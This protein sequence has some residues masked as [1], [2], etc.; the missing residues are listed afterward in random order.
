MSSQEPHRRCPSQGQVPQELLHNKGWGVLGAMDTSS[1]A[2]PAGEPTPGLARLLPAS[3][4]VL[5]EP[6]QGPEPGPELLLGLYLVLPRS[7]LQQHDLLHDFL[8]LGPEG[9]RGCRHGPSGVTSG[10]GTGPGS[11]H[12]PALSY[13]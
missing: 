12:T 11:L 10:V 3:P 9:R 6:L 2:W 8:F 1:L 5:T 7:L 13:P 4:L